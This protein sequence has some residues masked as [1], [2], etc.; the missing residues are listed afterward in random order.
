M[1]SSYG[2]ATTSQLTAEFHAAAL[3]A[4]HSLATRGDLPRDADE[5]AAA[6]LGVVVDLL[7][8]GLHTVSEIRSRQPEPVAASL[9]ATQPGNCWPM[10]GAPSAEALGLVSDT[11]PVEH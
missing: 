6:V 3:A 2:I 4:G 9:T 1:P 10:I 5:F 8:A 7:T 11:E